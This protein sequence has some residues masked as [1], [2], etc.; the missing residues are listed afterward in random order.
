MSFFPVR[1][2]DYFLVVLYEP[3][4]FYMNHVCLQRIR[5]QAYKEEVSCIK[6]ITLK[7]LSQV[8]LIEDCVSGEIV[9]Y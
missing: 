1:K 8:E 3:A 9:R 7:D 2:K 6:Q 4:T 5:Q